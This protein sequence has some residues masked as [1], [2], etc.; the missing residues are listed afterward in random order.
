MQE[1][2][3]NQRE[4]LRRPERTARVKKK[5]TLPDRRTRAVVV[6]KSI[7]GLEVL[8]TMRLRRSQGTVTFD[9]LVFVDRTDASGLAASGW[10]M[11]TSEYAA[12]NWR[13]GKT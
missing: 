8:D 9:N 10:L 12:W 11:K 5:E 6:R 4:S 3:V 2:D 13:Q 7:R 1:A